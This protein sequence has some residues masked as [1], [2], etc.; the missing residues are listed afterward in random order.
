MGIIAGDDSYNV[1]ISTDLDGGD[2]DGDI[3]YLLMKQVKGTTRNSDS[4]KIIAGEAVIKVITGKVEAKVVATKTKITGAK[5]GLNP[6]EEYN[7]IVTKFRDWGFKNG[8]TKVYFTVHNTIDDDY[9][10][11]SFVGGA[12]KKYIYGYIMDY[13][14]VLEKGNV[15]TIESLT[16]GQVTS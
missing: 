15:Y 6:T 13:S 3:I 14:W 4:K 2:P 16:F 9:M 12:A 8:S 5:S 11:L 10:V 7:A 1:A